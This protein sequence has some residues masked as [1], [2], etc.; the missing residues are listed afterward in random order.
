MSDTARTIAANLA[1]Y[2]KQYSQIRHDVLVHTVTEWEKNFAEL[3][4]TH[5]SWVGLYQG[6]FARR[7][8]GR[9]VLELGCGAG[10]NA[11]MMARHGADVTAIDI[12]EHSTTAVRRVADMVGMGNIHPLTGD[13]RNME[14]PAAS[15]DFVIA[16]EFIHHL[17]HELEDAYLAKAARILRPDGEVRLAEP[18]VNSRVLDA[19]RWI[20][21]VPGRPSVLSTRKFA[22]WKASDP[23]PRRANDSS[24]Y[25]TNGARFFEEITIT[26]FG[27]IERLHRLLPHG[28]NR[29]YRRWAHQAELR[30]PWWFR[31]KVARTNLVVY[32]RPRVEASEPRLVTSGADRRTW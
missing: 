21:P 32:R 16:K 20:V 30:L 29:Q 11:F 28:V 10:L 15:F 18:A 7:L 6:N 12:S 19:I 4:A 26:P 27:S 31:W 9:R 24:H 1:Y 23:H 5:V 17:T 22:E 3:T 14:F 13:F 2:D 25:L 8:A